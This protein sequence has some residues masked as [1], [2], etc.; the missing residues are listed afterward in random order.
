[1]S[2]NFKAQLAAGMNHFECDL[3][4]DSIELLKIYFNELKKWNRKV[5]LIPRSEQR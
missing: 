3:S 4:A 2:Y 5:N 1:M